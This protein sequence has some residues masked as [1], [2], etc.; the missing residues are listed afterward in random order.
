MRENGRK[1][2]QLAHQNH[3]LFTSVRTCEP[4]G[5]QSNISRP[6]SCEGYESQV[7]AFVRRRI[8]EFSRK[9]YQVVF[10][11]DVTQN[12]LRDDNDRKSH[13]RRYKN[14]D[15]TE[16]WFE[17][18]SGKYPRRHLIIWSH[19]TALRYFLTYFLM[20]LG[21]AFILIIFF[22][23]KLIIYRPHC[24]DQIT[25]IVNNIYILLIII[26]TNIY[27]LFYIYIYII[28]IYIYI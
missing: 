14:F 7:V 15:R 21:K 28:Y 6:W 2:C 1:A 18:G 17:Y 16:I 20:F 11:Y 3:D 5:C 9:S 10:F 22:N 4:F 23:N 24:K 25:L 12:S 27:I 13:P 8:Y 26:I 19:T